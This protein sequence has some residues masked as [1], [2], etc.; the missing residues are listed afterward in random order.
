MLCL[1]AEIELEMPHRV[2]IIGPVGNL[3]VHLHALRGEHL[4]ESRS[5]PSGVEQ[6]QRFIMRDMRRHTIRKGRP[7]GRVRGDVLAQNCVI[8]P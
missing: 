8:A 6:D 5:R 2:P 1:G 3:L 7:H 4:K